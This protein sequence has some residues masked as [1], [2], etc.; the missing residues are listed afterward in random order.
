ME[1]K[2]DIDLCAFCGKP[3]SD[4]KIKNRYGYSNEFYCSTDCADQYDQQ[5]RLGIAIAVERAEQKRILEIALEHER[6]L[7]REIASKKN[8]QPGSKSKEKPDDAAVARSRMMDW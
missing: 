8:K 1:N 3:C 6:D 4:G 2:N 5:W 7:K